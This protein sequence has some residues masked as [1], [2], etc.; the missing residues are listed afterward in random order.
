MEKEI[1][2]IENKT[3]AVISR[4][5]NW[6]F[7]WGLMVTILAIGLLTLISFIIPYKE[8]VLCSIK[9]HTQGRIVPVISPADGIIKTPLLSRNTLIDSNQLLFTV[10]FPAKKEIAVYSHT[11]GIYMSYKLNFETG[12]S[13]LK[14][15]TL[16][17]IVPQVKTSA[18]L[19]CSGTASLFDIS[20]LS[21]GNK[22]SIHLER[23]G[24]DASVSGQ[25]SSISRIPDRS[26]QYPF[27]I[28]L[29][30]G[31]IQNLSERGLIYY[32]QGGNA[33]VNYKTQKLVYKLFSFFFA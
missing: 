3:N 14:N 13:V 19:Y 22:V 9:F 12:N 26:G 18:D 5:P 31:E 7:R 33:V 2:L 25:I 10:Q 29:N 11:S 20:K 6:I 16:F 23:Y 8:T 32:N 4:P 15:D 1:K 24:K 28:R 27:L 17:Y 30:N 21:I